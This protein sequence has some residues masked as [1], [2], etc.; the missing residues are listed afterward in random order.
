MCRCRVEVGELTGVAADDLAEFYL[1]GRAAGTINL[2][3]RALKKIWEFSKKIGI[4]L[5]LWGEG[6]M[7]GLLVQ[8]GKEGTTENAVKQS[9]A[10]VNLIFEVMGKASP[11]K[12]ALVAKVKVSVMKRRKQV[13]VRA[14]NMW[15]VRAMGKLIRSLYRVPA[16][17]VSA[18][19][20]RC[21]VLQV[22]L[23]FGMKRFSDLVQVRVSDLT[24]T[25]EGDLEV[26]MRRSKTDQEGKGSS[27]FLS[28][29]RKS[30]FSIP[31]IVRWY[32]SS[33]GLSGE[34]MLFPRLRGSKGGETV[35]IRGQ[36]VSYGVASADLKAV[37]ERLNLPKV[38]MHSG[39]IGAATAAKEA[40]VSK[41]H[42]R[43]CG[44][45]KG[46]MVDHYVR[47]DKAGLV[48]SDAL[49]GKL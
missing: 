19:D 8:M 15:T 45:W 3:D 39:R 32:V 27:F 33:L 30:G 24:F 25:K 12:G 49:L 47:P 42:V 34:D 4:S 17:E 48:L 2:Y 23:F 22:M 11:T 29:R 13:A 7:V 37:L 28:G 9:M 14:R 40:G 26:K 1:D 16:S 31:E 46:D 10:C 44:G 20:R 5:F 41:D 38:S 18:Q 35:A 6:E 43:V 21:L 36:A